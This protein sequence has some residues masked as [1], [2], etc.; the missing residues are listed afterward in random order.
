MA[1]DDV[2]ELLVS[3]TADASDPYTPLSVPDLRLLIDRL[4]FRSHRLHASALSSA[5]SN[6]GVL[7]NALLCVASAVDSSASLESSLDSALAPLASWPDLSDL[8]A[9]ADAPS[10]PAATSLSARST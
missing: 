2:R 6:R 10:L 4:R 3:T 9:L 1:A 7:T 5:A 8:R